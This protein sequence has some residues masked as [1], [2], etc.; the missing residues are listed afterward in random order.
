MVENLLVLF[1]GSYKWAVTFS[2]STVHAIS[3]AE[4]VQLRAATSGAEGTILTVSGGSK[5][6]GSSHLN[7][8]FLGGNKGAISRSGS[9]VKSIR[10][11][12]PVQLRA[13]TSRAESTILTVSSLG[14]SFL[15][16]NL[17]SSSLDQLLSVVKE[18]T[19]T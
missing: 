6:L 12:E 5:S 17:L 1:S 14:K 16:G 13:A 3:T 19:V 4:P 15:G 10:A 2:G 7:Q 18:G 9:T 11:A 8:L